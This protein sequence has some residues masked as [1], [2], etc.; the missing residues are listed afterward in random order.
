[1]VATV[2]S[3]P[4]PSILANIERATV[5]RRR[6]D[7]RVKAQHK[8]RSLDV[9]TLRPGVASI[10]PLGSAFV[11]APRFVSMLFPVLD[12]PVPMGPAARE[13][14]SVLA[15]NP[16]ALSNPVLV[17][18]VEQ[19]AAPVVEPAPV[20]SKRKRAPLTEAQR[21]L[22]RERDARYRANRKAKRTV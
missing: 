12:H 14:L 21:Q 20:V 17:E 6:H 18:S 13:T 2:V 16:D 5:L 8:P 4:S 10:A 1:M 9:V 15:T 19:P 7:G 22:K 11:N 3:A